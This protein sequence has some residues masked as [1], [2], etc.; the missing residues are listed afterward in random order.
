MS[1]DRRS[2]LLRKVRGLLDKADGE[3]A[4]GNHEAGQAYRNKA[5]EMMANYA[6]EEFELAAFYKAR[7]PIRPEVRRFEYGSLPEEIR[8]PL[9]DMFGTMARHCGVRMGEYFYS[10]ATLVGYPQDLDYLEMLYTGV[11]LHMSA[12]IT[13]TPSRTLG[14]EASL[15]LLKETGKKW[16]EVYLALLPVFPERFV[17]TVADVAKK[18]KRDGYSLNYEESRAYFE[19]RYPDTPWE[20]GGTFKM[21]YVRVGDH[22]FYREVPRPIGVRFTK[23]YTE[24]C[25]ATS[26][27]RIYS[28]PTVYLRSFV[29]GYT[30]TIRSR[31]Y[32]MGR[33]REAAT[34][35][36][37]LVLVSIKQT[38][39]E[40][41]WDA[42]PNLKPHD[43]DC[44][45]DSCHGVCGSTTCRRPACI[46]YQKD[47]N[48][49]VRMST[50]RSA[51]YDPAAARRG[52][53]TAATADLSAATGKIDRNKGELG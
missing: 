40:A 1:D 42:F 20:Q 47:R 29:Q 7:G 13:P 18:P 49:P 43:D 26:R 31:L 37:E 23:E 9:I 53:S 12:N 25:K 11:R 22:V 46:R 10:H 6:I 27:E 15:A 34:S 50:A 33:I 36:K 3:E 41:L 35:G 19:E 8:K 51:V 52:S 21:N 45:C 44:D 48:K 14:Y 28:D 4:L 39:D 17:G 2:G 30:E 32:Q 16:K 5:D 24:F 38:L